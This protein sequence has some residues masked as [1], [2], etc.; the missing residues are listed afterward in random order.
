MSLRAA[1]KN[2]RA[3]DMTGN[4]V[5]SEL[6]PNTYLDTQISVQI[7]CSLFVTGVHLPARV[8]SGPWSQSK[9]DLLRLLDI[10]GLRTNPLDK[11]QRYESMKGAI[12]EGNWETVKTLALIG[13]ALDLESFRD[14]ILSSHGSIVQKLFDW[15]RNSSYIYWNHKEIREW[16][17][18]HGKE[19]LEKAEASP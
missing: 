17:G 2:I 8:L 9:V 10:W 11:L 6:F 7:A 14:L 16:V 18:H 19:E 15:V 4:T 12:V 1:V 3:S 13:P 5:R